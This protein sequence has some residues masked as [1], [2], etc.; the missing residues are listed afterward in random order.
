M[1]T[2]GQSP[3]G[4]RI[5]GYKNRPW[6]PRIWNG[7]NARGWIGLL[8]RNRF[9]VAPRRIPMALVN[10]V[11][12]VGI[13]PVLWAVQE[14]VYGWKIRRT[15]LVDDP[16]F[17]I[18]HWRTGTTLLHELMVLDERHTFPTSYQCFAPNHFLVSRY[19][20][21]IIVGWL[22]PKQRPQDDMPFGLDLPQE[23]E[24]ALCNMG[25]PSPY[26]TMAFPNRP[27]QCEQYFDMEGV[28]P[29]ELARWKRK[30]LW[31]L[32]CITVRTP[33]RIVLK[34]PPH[35]GRV[36]VLKEMFPQAKFIHIYRDPIT[37]FA[38]TMNLWRR[39]WRDQGLQRPRYE[40]LEDYVLVT[41]N[42]VYRAFERDRALLAENQLV[43]VRYESLVA[44][45]LAQMERIYEQLELGQFDRVRP[46]VEAFLAA[47]AGYKPNRYQV[48]DEVRR[49]I[50]DQW[51][52]FFDKYGYARSDAPAEPS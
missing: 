20:L 48:S 51:G 12:S 28:P 40:G 41:F 4:E 38:S 44:D 30:L 47:R 10:T 34:S 32:K 9:Q 3:A 22:S 1:S 29:A 37:V 2:E 33:K 18:G 11:I 50:N 35:L 39:F 15:Q 5:G 25:L 49:K 26:L 27:P 45:P 21:G 7:M 31:F 19:T 46:A 52:W 36:R 23:D 43:E 14:A 16:I 8:A 13:N 17:I 24:F 42:R 6:I